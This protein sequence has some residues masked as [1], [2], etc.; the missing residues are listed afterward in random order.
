MSVDVPPAPRGSEDEK[1]DTNERRSVED[2][3]WELLVGA[4]KAKADQAPEKSS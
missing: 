2:L 4:P 1:K 3:L